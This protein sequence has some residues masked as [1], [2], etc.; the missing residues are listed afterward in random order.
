MMEILKFGSR[1][2]FTLAHRIRVGKT[3]R[4]MKCALSSYGGSGKSGKYKE[5]KDDDSTEILDVFEE[6][7]KLA[8]TV[9]DH[10]ED[11]TLDDGELGTNRFCIFM[12]LS[13]F[14][15]TGAFWHKG[16]LGTQLFSGP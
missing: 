8:E 13:Q 7:I 5:F 1:L 6:R 12:C 2:S 11:R 14:G 16:I 3:Y 4:P 9:A 10:I 15:E